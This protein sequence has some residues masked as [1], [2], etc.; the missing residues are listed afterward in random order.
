MRSA[1]VSGYEIDSSSPHIYVIGLALITASISVRIVWSSSTERVD[2]P[3]TFFRG[4][5]TLRINF[6]QNPPH[7]GALSTINFHV[8]RFSARTCC[9]SCEGTILR[10]SLSVALKVFALSESSV[11][12]KPRRLAHLLNGKSSFT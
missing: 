4:R 2:L 7:H 8:I 12:G 1:G 3:I 6:S 5:F 10:N 11:A 9:T